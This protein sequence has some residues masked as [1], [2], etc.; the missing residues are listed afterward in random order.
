MESAPLLT[1]DKAL[2][3]TSSRHLAEDIINSRLAKCKKC[4][5]TLKQLINIAAIVKL[6]DGYKYTWKTISAITPK[7]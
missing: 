2:S 3:I 1:S 7:P 6:S 5:I 4:E